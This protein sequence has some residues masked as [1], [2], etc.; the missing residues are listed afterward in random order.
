MFLHFL[1]LRKRK[2]VRGR[3]ALKAFLSPFSV[4]MNVV[5]TEERIPSFLPFI[6]REI[7]HCVQN[8]NRA[9]LSQSNYKYALRYC[10]QNDNG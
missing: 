10:V 6:P 3:Y 5:Q 9:K 7:L 8:D 2:N 4:I 1:V